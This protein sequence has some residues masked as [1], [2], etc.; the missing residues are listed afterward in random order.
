MGRRRNREEDV[1]DSLELEYYRK[2]QHVDDSSGNDSQNNEPVAPAEPKKIEAEDDKIEKLAAT[3]KPN[4]TSTEEDKIEKLRLKKQHRKELKKGKAQKRKEQQ[5][6]T[7][8]TRVEEE[9]QKKKT[10]QEKAAAKKKIENPQQKLVQCR[11]GV[12][13][14]DVVVGKG[15]VVKDRKKVHVKYVLRAKTRYGKIIDSND[16]F[17]FRL[18]RGEVIEGWDIGLE[19]MRSGG[20]RYLIVPPQAGYGDKNIGGGPGVMLFFDVS[21]LS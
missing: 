14:Q 4:G 11:K 21:L 3:E 2:R 16:D 19:G 6:E 12:Q 13:Y 18:G 8:K 5:Q 9:E 17:G 7:E 15:P 1:D 20:R 10:Q